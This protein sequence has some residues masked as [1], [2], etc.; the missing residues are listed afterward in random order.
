MIE[1]QE[2]TD[3]T[4]RV[5]KTAFDGSILPDHLCHQ[6]VGFDKML[7]CFVYDTLSYEETYSRCFKTPRGEFN[8]NGKK[9]LSLIS[10]DDTECFSMKKVIVQTNLTVKDNSFK[11]LIVINGFG[12]IVTNE[13]KMSIQKGEVYFLPVSIKA[14]E[15]IN[16]CKSTLE[17][18]FCYP[19]V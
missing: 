8:D 3:F 12:F 9:I 13:K 11:S 1:I 7:D 2:P 10:K 6:G 16:N 19:P 14:I 17:C 5:E 15:L 4:M 18:I